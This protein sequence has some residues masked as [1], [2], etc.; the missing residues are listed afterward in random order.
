MSHP[1]ETLLRNAY[2]LFAKGDVAGF[3]A[4]CTPDIRFRVPGTNA[5]SGEHGTSEFLAKLGP[6]ME[7]TGNSFREEIR[8]LAANDSDGFV[9]AA[10]KVERD[11]R[12]YAWNAVHHYRFVGGKLASF[13]EFTDDQ[14]TFDR[15]WRPRG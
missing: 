14:A 3:L 5:L 2:A 11:G 4:L 1:N 15:A 10:Q 6:M 13:T 8:N 7:L 9:L 12:T